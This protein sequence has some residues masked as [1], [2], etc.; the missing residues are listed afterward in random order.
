VSKSNNAIAKPCQTRSNTV[1]K[2]KSFVTTNRVVNGALTA[3][4][5]SVAVLNGISAVRNLKGT[6]SALVEGEYL[7]AAARAATAT[8]NTAVA[9]VFTLC[10]K[11]SAMAAYH[12]TI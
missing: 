12:D 6:G 2:I 10:A 3:A 7:T 1:A 8:F 11:D 4:Y 5:G 9:A